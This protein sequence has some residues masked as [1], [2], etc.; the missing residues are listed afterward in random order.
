MLGPG[1]RPLIGLKL[2]TNLVMVLLGQK[3][4]YYSHKRELFCGQQRRPGQAP[5]DRMGRAMKIQPLEIRGGR[6]FTQ[7]I[8]KSKRFGSMTL[9][10]MLFMK[11]PPETGLS[12]VHTT[13]ERP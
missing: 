13:Q 10:E 2:G 11:F 7:D 3:G 5:L 6:N 4:R 1:V 8:G 9:A 12:Q